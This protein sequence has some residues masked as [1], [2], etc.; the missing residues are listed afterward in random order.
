MALW[1]RV[2]HDGRECFGTVDGVLE[3][4]SPDSLPQKQDEH[5]QLVYRARVRLT[6]SLAGMAARGIRLR[7]GQAPEMAEHRYAQLLE[8][9]KGQLH[10]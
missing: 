10:L 8:A 1:A 7:P 6:G 9:R 4:I 5:A 3:V 2:V